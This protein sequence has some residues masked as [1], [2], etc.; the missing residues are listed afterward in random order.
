M[1]TFCKIIL[2]VFKCNRAHQLPTCVQTW[3]FLGRNSTCRRLLT[4]PSLYVQNI[5][6]PHQSQ[7]GWSWDDMHGLIHPLY[8]SYPCSGLSRAMSHCML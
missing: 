1:K 6:A 5:E 8:L 2:G 7:E 4:V 3:V